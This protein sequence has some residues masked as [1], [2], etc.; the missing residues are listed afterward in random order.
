MIASLGSPPASQ[1]LLG[2]VTVATGGGSPVAAQVGSTVASGLISAT[3]Q[4]SCSGVPAGHCSAPAS[5]PNRQIGAHVSPSTER[6]IDVAA[7]PTS[8]PSGATPRHASGG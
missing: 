1:P 2:L 5:S 4:R 6:T 3:L 8:A 7:Q